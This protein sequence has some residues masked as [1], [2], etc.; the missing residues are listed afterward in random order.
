MVICQND[1]V[2]RPLETFKLEIFQANC[3][4]ASVSRGGLGFLVN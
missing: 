3:G 4:L 2:R 1:C